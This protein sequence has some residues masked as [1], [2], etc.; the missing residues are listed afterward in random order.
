MKSILAQKLY[1]GNIW[2]ITKRIIFG[3]F[4]QLTSFI[5]AIL[6]KFYCFISP[7]APNI[8]A[9]SVVPELI[10]NGSVHCWWSLL[11]LTCTFNSPWTMICTYYTHTPCGD[12]NSI[13]LVTGP[14]ASCQIHKITGRACAGEPGTFSPPPQFSD[15]DMHH[16]NVD[17]NL[18]Q[19]MTLP[20]SHKFPINGHI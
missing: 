1:G 5:V 12:G 6:V 8:E 18:R 7:F 14:R 20:C 15:P 3:F 2:H 11:S 4:I 10:I 13:V 17:Q 16:G 19:H 9:K